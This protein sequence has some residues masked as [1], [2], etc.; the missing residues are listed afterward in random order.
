VITRSTTFLH[1]EIVRHNGDCWSDYVISGA[2]GISR[3][4]SP[5]FTAFRWL[6]SALR[7][8]RR[9]VATRTPVCTRDF[10]NLA[11]A[12]AL[13]TSVVSITFDS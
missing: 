6:V 11:A 12:P 4:C 10:T 2:V 9:T 8:C 7:L 3:P 13:H 5:L 1:G